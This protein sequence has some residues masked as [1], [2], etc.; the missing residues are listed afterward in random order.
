MESYVGERDSFDNE[1]F[2][3]EI[4]IIDELAGAAELVMKKSDNIPVAILRGVNY[5]SSDLGVRDLIRKED[6]DFF[7]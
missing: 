7:L 3:T 1:L 4:A 6:E 5:K 2:A